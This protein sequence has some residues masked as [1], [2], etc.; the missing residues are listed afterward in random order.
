LAFADSIGAGPTSWT[1]G[2]W[3]GPADATQDFHWKGT[4]FSNDAAGAVRSVGSSPLAGGDSLTALKLFNLAD[5]NALAALA[6]HAIHTNTT[7]TSAG[8]TG[9]LSHL[10]EPNSCLL[11]MLVVFGVVGWVVQRR[12]SRLAPVDQAGSTIH[13]LE[14]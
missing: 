9:L 2:Y 3:G 8:R 5:G 12:E 7:P 13:R 1:E 4:G 14:V 11:P 10:P 6:G